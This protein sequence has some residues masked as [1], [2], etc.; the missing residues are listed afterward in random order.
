MDGAMKRIGHVKKLIGSI[1]YLSLAIILFPQT[2]SGQVIW[3]PDSGFLSREYRPRWF[4]DYENFG[5]YDL[6]KA[7]VYNTEAYQTGINASGAA[8][9]QTRQVMSRVSYDPFGNF[10]LPGGDVWNMKW[11][12]S[13]LGT[14]A[15]NVAADPTAGTPFF[16]ASSVFNNLMISSDEF[17]NWQT[18]LMIGT[19][20]RTLFTPSTL[21]M[22]NYLGTTVPTVRWDASNRKNSVTLLAQ[23]NQGSNSISALNTLGLHWQ[24]ILGDKLKV[25]GTLINR[26]RGSQMYSHTDIDNGLNGMRDTP[27]YIYLVLTDASPGDFDNGPRIYQIKTFINGNDYSSQVLS[28]VMKIP[29][30]L[31]TKRYYSGAFQ[32]QYV[33]ARASGQDFYPRRPEDDVS[34]NWFLNAMGSVSRDNNLSNLLSKTDNTNFFGLLNLANPANPTDPQGR[35]YAADTSLGYQEASGTDVVIYEFFIPPEARDVKFQVLAA[36]D[37]NID[38]IAAY[39]RFVQTGE[40]SWNDQPFSPALKNAW[41]VG[42]DY[43]NVA[44]AQ[45]NVK[46]YSN[47][48]WV[49]VAYDRWTGWNSYGI[50]AQFVWRGLKINGEINEY[51][52]LFSFPTEQSL[53]GGGRHKESARAWFA[54]LEQDFGTW[55]FGGEVY[56][57]PRGYMRYSPAIDNAFFGTASAGIDVDFDNLNDTNWGSTPYLTY[58]YDLSPTGGYVAFG[59][60]FNHDGSI[61]QRQNYTMPYDTDSEGNHIFLKLKPRPMTTFTFGRYDIQR[62]YKKGENLTNYLKWE[63]FAN[64]HNYLEYSWQNRVERIPRDDYNAYYIASDYWKNTSF[65]HTRLYSGNLNVY[66]DVLYS[67]TKSY[68]PILYPNSLVEHT[69]VL[70]PIKPSRISWSLTTVH[71]ADYVWRVAD[72]RLLPDIFI[73]GFRIMKEKRIREMRLQPQIYFSNAYSTA[74]SLR[75]NQFYIQQRWMA[76]PVI[77]F[78]YRVAPNTLFRAGFQGFPGIFPELNR[79]VHENRYDDYSI[80][81]ESD[82]SRMV[83]A[84]E[85]RTL[86]QGFNLLVQAGIRKDKINYL[87]SRGRLQ[88]G[89]TEYFITLQSEGVR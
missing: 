65:L 88:P 38:L 61:D 40:A 33:F 28:R 85:N 80:L 58:Y 46:D 25:G 36:N 75:E 84:F 81:N 26:Q 16:Y 76:F 41:S 10:L 48:G 14:T 54:N 27:R 87:D 31:N 43:R 52:A 62:T 56:N 21:R 63:H 29:D 4:Q 82:R 74:Y 15:G 83:L 5:S 69:Q 77:R 22:N 23:P 59:D 1:A 35:L 32:Q 70:T 86:Y 3:T 13:R 60:D 39:Y 30:I 66:N 79:V 50:D 17:S 71:K 57:Y 68:N 89:Q 7:P 44:L 51:N 78:D 64:Y 47:M 67:F 9:Y 24:S 2:S 55:G 42:Y 11:D 45:G 8:M 6:R 34:S 49:T 72:A 18:K 19:S 20:I 53:G 73:G 12:T 37:Y